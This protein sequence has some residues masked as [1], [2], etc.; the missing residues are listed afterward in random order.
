MSIIDQ[1]QTHQ[2]DTKP[3]SRP[4]W[5]WIA[6]L[7]LLAA[8]ALGALVM[9]LLGLTSDPQRSTSA[10]NLQVGEPILVSEQQ[11]RHYGEEN[12]PIYWNGPQTDTQYELTKSTSGAIFIRYLPKGKPVGTTDPF[13]TVA[14]YPE[15]QGYDHLKDAAASG[16]RVSSQTTTND[17]LVLV[18]EHSPLSTHFSFP[19]QQFQVEVFS[20]REG[21]SKSDVLSGT[22]TILRGEN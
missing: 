1:E 10:L 11:L 6:L 12:G 15:A 5:Y 20:P 21:E 22:V 18:R 14:T 16:E 2:T 17:A 8:L 7:A 9:L 13:L 4:R 3:R 19:G